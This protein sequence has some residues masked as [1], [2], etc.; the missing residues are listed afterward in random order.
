MKAMHTDLQLAG[1]E[2]LQKIL[3]NENKLFLE[4]VRKKLPI[5]EILRQYDKVR[6]LFD[7]IREKQDN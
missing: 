2:S 4:A 6:S 1:N 5:D 3:L 7:T